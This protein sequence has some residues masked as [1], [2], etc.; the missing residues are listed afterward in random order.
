MAGGKGGGW[1]TRNAA[2]LLTRRKF[3]MRHSTDETVEATV[4]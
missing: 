2:Y 3:A 1:Q 4:R